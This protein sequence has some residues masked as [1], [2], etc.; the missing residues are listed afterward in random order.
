MIVWKKI[1]SAGEE[2]AVPWPIC[3]GLIDSSNGA[4]RN[5]KVSELLILH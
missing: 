5:S 3:E 2:T 4:R 1:P